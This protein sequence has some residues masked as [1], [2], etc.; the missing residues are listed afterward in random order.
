MTYCNPNAKFQNVNKIGD[1][2]LSVQLEENLK[3]FL[4]WGFLNIGG[5][6]NINRP[7]SNISNNVLFHKLSKKEDP[8]YKS[9]QIW[10]TFKKQWVYETGV[11]YQSA[12]PIT[13]SGLYINNSFV[14]GPTGTAQY[15]FKLNY[16]LGRVIFN[17]GLPAN[18]DIQMNFSY[19]SIQVYKAQ[20]NLSEWKRLQEMTF[21]RADIDKDTSSNHRI[22]LPCII[23]E[24]INVANFYPYELGSLTYNVKQ[25][26]LLHVFTENYVDRNNIMDILR[27]QQEK[28]LKLYDINKVVSNQVYSLNKDGSLNSNRKNYDQLFD[29]DQYFWRISHINK[30]DIIDNQSFNYNLFYSTI[31]L[32]MEIVV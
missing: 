32:G 31:R 30:I 4:N 26:I 27:L 19:R 22:Q 29:D 20:E 1:H 28:V 12:S 14:P 5:F 11:S 7:T 6:I 9:G 15:P 13:I 3:S 10:E 25:D 2:L 21:K 18:T 17:S 24:P 23:I 16:D 8:L